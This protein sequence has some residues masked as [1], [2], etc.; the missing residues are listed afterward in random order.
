MSFKFDDAE[1]GYTRNLDLFKS[2]PIDTGIYSRQWV[3]FRPVTQISKGS[4][5]QFTIPGSSPAYK[6]LSKIRLHIKC[7]ILKSNGLPVSK[8]DDVSFTNLTLASLFRQCDV[9]LQQ[10]NVSSN[11]GMNYSYKAMIDT[12]LKYDEDPKESQLQSQ[13]YFKDSAGY[14]DDA[15]AATGLNLGILQRH[16]ATMEGGSVDLEGPIHMDI[17]QQNRLLINGVPL[18]IKFHP[19]TDGF[20]LMSPQ[21]GYQYEIQEAILKVCMVTLN[22]AV[23]VAHSET[24]KKTPALYPYMRSDFRTFNIQPGSYTWGMDDI[25]QNMIPSRV[26][27]A[28]VSGQAYSG[29]YNKNPY[30]F[31][32]F[33]CNF[34]GLYADGISVPGEPF[35]CDYKSGHFVTPYLS[36]FTAIGKFQANEGNYISREDYP[37]GYAL[38]VFDIE[39][40]HGREYM[41]LVKRGHSRL[42]I[43]F[44]Q[45]PK[46]TV[47]VLIYSH[48]PAMLQVDESRNIIK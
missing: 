24:L 42:N 47:T 29:A 6:D 31:Q 4:P 36:L 23:L 15:S 2:P 20:V 34:M 17:C 12:L 32:H 28:L 48:F 39:G 21:K 37:K 7:R 45:A 9:A 38:Y 41:N 3:S 43:R 16:A 35:Q 13:Y 1:E 26:V 19:N 46:E 14:M 30:N 27:V 8:E 18:D 22:P 40:K 33:T 10:T 44:E 25:F 5:I 11:I